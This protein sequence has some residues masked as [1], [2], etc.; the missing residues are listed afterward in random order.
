MRLSLF[1]NFSVFVA[2][3]YGACSITMAF[4]NK[5]LLTLFLY[6]YEF[7]IMASQMAFTVVVLE[8]LRLSV[9]V[10]LMRYNFERGFL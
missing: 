4:A 9:R 10:N 8:V 2:V 7:F 1:F 5:A 3:C 6:D